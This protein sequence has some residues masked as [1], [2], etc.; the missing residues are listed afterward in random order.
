MNKKI[1]LP[2]V[3]VLAASLI[4]LATIL[5]PKFLDKDDTAPSSS[6]PLNGAT[7][8]ILS[9]EELESLKDTWSDFLAS[10]EQN[11]GLEIEVIPNT[12]SDNVTSGSST[13][14]GTT[15]NNS[16]TSTVTSQEGTTTNSSTVESG[17][18]T[19]SNTTTSEDEY[20]PGIW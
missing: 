18:T 14:S 4:I 16:T 9:G 12:S 2:L 6:Q 17:N 10:T 13:V 5:L 15:S 20:F 1:I 19:T 7:G 3:I 11:G 8:D